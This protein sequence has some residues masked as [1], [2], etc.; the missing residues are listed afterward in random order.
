MGDIDQ[1]P[2]EIIKLIILNLVITDKKYD[3]IIKKA[4]IKYKPKKL[5]KIFLIPVWYKIKSNSDLVSIT[6]YLKKKLGKKNSR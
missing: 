4:F 6:Q 1:L 5:K 3:N 2:V